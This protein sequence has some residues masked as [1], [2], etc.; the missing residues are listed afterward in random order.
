MLPSWIRS[1]NWR[2]R[3]VYFLAIEMTRRR[4]ASTISFFAWRASRSPFCTMCTILRNSWISRP[5]SPASAWISLRMCLMRS[6]SLATKFFQPLAERFDL[7]DDL[8]FELLVFVLLGG[9]Q[10]TALQLERDVLVLQPAQALVAV[11]D[12]V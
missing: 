2:P 7:A 6:L 9:R 11:G 8:L 5:V 10:R 12:C 1:R 3:L 4:F